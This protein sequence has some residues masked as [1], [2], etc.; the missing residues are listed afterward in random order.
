MHQSGSQLNITGDEVPL[1]I[2]DEMVDFRNLEQH[3]YRVADDGGG[4]YN[5]RA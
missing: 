4:S 2:R 3:Q 1:M 5:N